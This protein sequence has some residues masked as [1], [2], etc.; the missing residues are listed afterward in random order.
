MELSKYSIGIGDRF[1]HEAKA[2]LKAVIDANEKLINITPVWNKSFREHSIIHS[3]PSDTRI[4][5][6]KAIKELNW[7]KQYFIDAD[8]I[9]MS[10]VDEFISYSDYFTI[11][12]ADFIGNTDKEKLKKSIHQNF[13]FIGEINIPNISQPFK[14][15]E[16]ELE[17]I[18]Q[19]YLS[20]ITEAG[21]I[22]RFIESKKGTNNYITEISIDE[23]L[24]PQSPIE[25]LIILSLLSI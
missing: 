15:S 12:I 13:E 17:N 22:Y 6:D 10:N 25:L 18:I 9:N 16:K 21:M 14:L 24:E 20:A 8:H 19:K 3:K 23:V 5:V 7:E 2:Q 1:G 4:T 11:D